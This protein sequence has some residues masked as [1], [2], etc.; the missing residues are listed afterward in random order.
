MRFVLSLHIKHGY[1]NN[2][3]YEFNPINLTFYKVLKFKKWIKIKILPNYVIF[4]LLGWN[5]VVY[6]LPT[7]SQNNI[8]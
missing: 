4:S 6:L 2:L 8:L 7:F 1:M 3:I 5:H